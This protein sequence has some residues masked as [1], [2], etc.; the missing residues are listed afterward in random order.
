MSWLAFWIVWT[1]GG[2]IVAGKFAKERN[3][4][5]QPVPAH[6]TPLHAALWIVAGGPIIWILALLVFVGA[7]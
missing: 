5:E 6:W 4:L 3:K 7:A 1:L 2:L